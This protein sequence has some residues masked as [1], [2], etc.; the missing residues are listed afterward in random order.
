[1][2]LRVSKGPSG[3]MMGKKVGYKVEKDIPGVENN[4][5]K[6]TDL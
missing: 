2:L 4:V 1:M 3:E 6:I 5:R